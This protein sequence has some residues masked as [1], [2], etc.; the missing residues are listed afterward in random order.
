MYNVTRGLVNSTVIR[1]KM[2]KPK[3]LVCGRKILWHEKLFY[4]YL[5]QLNCLECNSIMKH[6]STTT[7][8]SFILMLAT[9]ILFSYAIKDG[10]NYNYAIAS[11]VMFVAMCVFLYKAKLILVFKDGRFVKNV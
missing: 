11:L 5:H 1:K 4:N 7:I 6:S 2:N 10:I 8:I 9:L 3:C